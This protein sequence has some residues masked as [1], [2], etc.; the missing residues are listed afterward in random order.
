MMGPGKLHLLQKSSVNLPA[1]GL[2]TRFLQEDIFPNV[3][4]Q[5]QDKQGRAPL[6]NTLWWSECHPTEPSPAGSVSNKRLKASPMSSAILL[7]ARGR[8]E[9]ENYQEFTSSSVAAEALPK[10]SAPSSS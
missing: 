8:T 3:S 6:L 7:L 10:I 4:G 2:E 5:T 1:E 9:T